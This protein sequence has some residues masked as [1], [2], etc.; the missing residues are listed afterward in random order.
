MRSQRRSSRPSEVQ[1]N[2]GRREHTAT[3]RPGK[4][5]PGTG[6]ISAKLQSWRLPLS[7]AL[8]E[9]CPHRSRLGAALVARR[10]FAGCKSD[11]PS[12]DSAGAPAGSAEAA[13]GGTRNRDRDRQGFP[14]DAPGTIPAG[15]VRSSL[16]NQGKEMHQAQ[17]IKLEDGKT[18]AGPL[19]SLKTHGPPPDWMK[20]VGGP[21]AA[22][23]GHEVERH[24]GARARVTTPGSASFPARTASCTPP[25]GWSGPSR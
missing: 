14:F 6:G 17:L 11:R 24:I 5:R 15:A 12:T 8:E 4:R 20:F 19:A 22:A 3:A 21:N 16:V 7:T 13:E 1:V 23:P 25:R 18:M 10:A 2:D 9:S